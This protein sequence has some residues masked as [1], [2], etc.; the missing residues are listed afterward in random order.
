MCFYC[1]ENACRQTWWT[2]NEP[3][4]L[5]Y[6][7]RKT[8]VPFHNFISWQDQRAADLVKSW[9]R[10]YTLKVSRCLRVLFLLMN[11]VQ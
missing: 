3:G 9:N 7:Y 4:F 11:K 2:C 10:S 8:G 6:S 5:F 1:L